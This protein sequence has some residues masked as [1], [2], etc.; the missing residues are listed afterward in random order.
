MFDVSKVKHGSTFAQ[1]LKNDVT[2]KTEF[3]VL[4]TLKVIYEYS[5]VLRSI[6]IKFSFYSLNFSK[7][8]IVRSGSVDVELALVQQAAVENVCVSFLT[9]RARLANGY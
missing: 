7:L 5:Y 2:F 6:I 1:H 4:H 3:K 8:L 9:T